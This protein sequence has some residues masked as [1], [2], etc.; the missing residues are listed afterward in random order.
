MDFSV[1]G[2]V[3]VRDG[4]QDL[5]L[6]AAMPRRV[7]ATLLLNAGRIVSHATLSEELWDQE[8]PRLARKTIQTYLYQLRKMLAGAPSTGERQWLETRP[9]GYRIVLQPGEL[10]LHVFQQR[11]SLGRAALADN[12]HAR[13]A[14]LLRESLAL[15]RGS[16]LDD[17]VHGPV[18]AAEAARLEETRLATL[19][20]RI[21]VDLRIGRHRELVAELQTLTRQHP[22]R[23]EF[24]AQLL[25]A[26][27]RSGQREEALGCYARLRRNVVD[28]AGLEPSERLQRLHNAVLASAPGLN[29]PERSPASRPSVRIRPAEI[30][31]GNVDIVGRSAEMATLE[32]RLGRPGA[33]VTVSGGPGSGKT[34]LAVH[35]AQRVKDRFPDG[36]LFLTL[37]DPD[38]R[39]RDP[40]DA[41]HSLLRTTAVGEL[42]TSLEES[43]RRFRSW[44]ADRRVLLLLDDAAANDQIAHLLPGGRDCATIVTSRRRLAGLPHSGGVSLDRLSATDA[45]ALLATAAGPDRVAAD[46]GAALEL[47]QRCDLLPLAVWT[48]GQ[49][50]AARPALTAAELAGRLAPEQSRLAELSIADLD[51]RQ[52]FDTALNRLDAGDRQTLAL[53][54]GL[55]DREFDLAELGRV[56]GL[57]PDRAESRI[58]AV[59]DAHLLCDRDQATGAGFRVPTLVRLSCAARGQAP[60]AHHRRAEGQPAVRFRTASRLRPR[61][62]CSAGPAGPHIRG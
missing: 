10:D 60:S 43:A 7:L 3:E 14:R 4:V 6:A 50:L 62:H 31:S 38:G 19:E 35:A 25:L 2:P 30:P 29:M 45:L 28:Q 56:L 52:R 16:P 33:V 51:V 22:L 5:T 23:E 54:A 32:R 42:P 15:W 27:Y 26:A 44:T 59:L 17:V 20:Q 58:E 8:P 36:Q 49:R 37:H 21:E 11:L 46:R 13:A 41:L 39:P 34:A 9:N 18:L 1:L 47:V 24:A 55:G 12:D 48:A 40:L 61:V 57:R 53:L